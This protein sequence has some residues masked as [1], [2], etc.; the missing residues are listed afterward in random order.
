MRFGIRRIHAL[1]SATSGV[2]SRRPVTT[3]ECHVTT[4]DCRVA[5]SLHVPCCAHRLTPSVHTSLTH[6]SL[7]LWRL[8]E[9]RRR[10]EP[11]RRRR[12]EGVAQRRSAHRVAAAGLSGPAAPS[13]AQAMPRPHPAAPTGAQAHNPLP[14]PLHV[15]PSSVEVQLAMDSWAGQAGRPGNC[16]ATG[17]PGGRGDRPAACWPPGRPR[18]HTKCKS[19]VTVRQPLP[20]APKAK[21]LAAGR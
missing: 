19:K 1:S 13:G 2:T 17:G 6:C 11:C 10:A 4:P 20:N 21:G 15:G 3:L 9:A 18:S 5:L 12:G 7:R 16:P 14:C 8:T